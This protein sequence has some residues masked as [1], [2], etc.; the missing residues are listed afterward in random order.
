MITDAC[1]HNEYIASYKSYWKKLAFIHCSPVH[2]LYKTN[3]PVV[4]LPSPHM[5]GET[6]GRNY[7][8]PPYHQKCLGA[9]KC[10]WFQSGCSAAWLDAQFSLAE[11]VEKEQAAHAQNSLPGVDED[12]DLT[13][14]K[15]V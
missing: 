2:N 9:H 12:C 14:T 8:K 15:S 13:A 6:N 10:N 11:Q 7:H 4:H 5:K 3:H 1:N